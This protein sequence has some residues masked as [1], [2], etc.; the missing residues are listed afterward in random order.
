[1]TNKSKFLKKLFVDG[2]GKWSFEPEFSNRT[3]DNLPKDAWI[4]FLKTRNETSTTRTYTRAFAVEEQ[5]RI[6]L[7]GACLTYHKEDSEII[8]LS[9]TDFDS[10]SKISQQ[11]AFCQY[12][13]C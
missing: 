12:I 10:Y 8:K 11:I 3:E 4:G 6:L 2:A 5:R 1:M 13:N 7:V 9:L